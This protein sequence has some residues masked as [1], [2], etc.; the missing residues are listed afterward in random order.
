MS[1]HLEASLLLELRPITLL[2]RHAQR[3]DFGSQPFR[4]LFLLRLAM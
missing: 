3:L 4:F 1:F 2:I